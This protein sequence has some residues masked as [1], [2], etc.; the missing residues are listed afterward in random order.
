MKTTPNARQDPNG[1]TTSVE[2]TVC[3]LIGRPVEAPAS[4]TLASEGMTH[5][6]TREGATTVYSGRV[7]AGRSRLDLL[8]RE[9]SLLAGRRR[10][11]RTGRGA[12]RAL[13]R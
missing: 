1:K 8:R 6:L 12:G 10:L 4:V 2:I 9:A 5:N 7:P 11:E 3:D 13:H